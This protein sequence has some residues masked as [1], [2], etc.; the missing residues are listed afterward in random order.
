[1]VHYYSG[2][3][4]VK[5]G[6]FDEAAK[7][8]ENELASNPGDVQAKYHLAFVLFAQQKTAAGVELMR[9]VIQLKPDFADAYYE[10]GKAL[11]QQ[12]QIKDAVSNLEIAAKLT[13]DKSYVQYQ[14]GRAYLAAGRKADGESHLEISRQLKEKERQTKP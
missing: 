9:E 13:P 11:L 8:F 7:E 12:G 2:L 10:L 4:F 14:L 3:I 1:M 5:A 6:K